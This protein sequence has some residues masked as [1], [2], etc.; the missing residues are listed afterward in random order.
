M[1]LT[2]TIIDVSHHNE[3]SDFENLDFDGMMIRA[4]Y[5]KT[6]DDK[7]EEFTEWAKNHKKHIGYYYYSYAINSVNME[8]EIDKFLDTVEEVK[9]ACGIEITLPLAVDIE[10]ADSYK[11]KKGLRYDTLAGRIFYN[12]L[13]ITACKAIEKSGYYAMIYASESW[14]EDILNYE[15]TAKYDHWVAKWSETKPSLQQFGMW[16]YTSNYKNQHCDCSKAFYNYPEIIARMKS[17]SLTVKANDSEQFKLGEKVKI[18]SPVDYNGI[19]LSQWTTVSEFTIMQ[20]TNDRVVIGRNEKVTC[21]V[22][23]CNLRKI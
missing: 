7:V 23:I 5:G 4:S 6:K 19:Q 1:G 10:D 15:E 13:A 21:A 16:Q 2:M 8:I 9:K 22:N 18:I 20:I 12:Q 14:F 11:L 3:I 17:Y